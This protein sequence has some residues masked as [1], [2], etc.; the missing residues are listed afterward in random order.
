MSFARYLCLA[1]T[2]PRAHGI[3]EVVHVKFLE[4]CP[5]QRARMVDALEERLNL[6]GSLCRSSKSA[7]HT[8][9]LGARLTD[10]PLVACQVLAAILRLSS[11]RGGCRSPRSKVRFAYSGLYLKDSIFKG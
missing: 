4:A 11:R 7:L 1:G 8:F 3:T 2:S 10:S 5:R 9:A 6:N